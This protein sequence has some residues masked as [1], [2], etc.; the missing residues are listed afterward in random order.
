ML[1]V[2][3]ASDVHLAPSQ[4]PCSSACAFSSAGNTTLESEQRSESATKLSVLVIFYLIVMIVEI[5]GGLK[6]NSLAVITD[7]VH[8]LTDVA[9]FSISLFAVWA[10]GWEA[11]SDQSFGY[12]RLEV[13]GAFISVQLIWLISGSLIYEAVNRILHKH[14]EVNGALMFSVAAFGFFINLIMVS[15]L[16]HNHAHHA[17]V[18]KDHNHAHHDHNHAHHAC[19][20]EDHNHV[21]NHEDELYAK[22]EVENAKLVSSPP[23]ESKILNIN[24]EGAYLHVITDLIQSIGVM[25]AGV[26]IWAKPNWLVVDLICTLVFSVLSLSA[27]LPMLRNIFCILMERTPSEIDVASLESGLKSIKGVRNIHDLHVWAITAGKYVL[28]CHL[29]AEPGV[30][31]NEVLCKVRD[32]CE[33]TYRIRH[34]TVQVEQ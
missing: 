34:I 15:W 4:S 12:S 19:V 8:L 13:F 24:L 6:A 3:V 29:V 14:S 18:D 21:H 27:T 2:P 9:G 7:A 5:V 23:A 1:M 33:T 11:T 17:C 22:D 25:I 16:G 28:S 20:D 32:Y 31:S 30:S 26:V 10:S